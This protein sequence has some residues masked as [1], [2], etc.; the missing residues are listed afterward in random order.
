MPCASNQCISDS[1]L[2]PSASRTV[3]RPFIFRQRGT[4]VNAVQ[5]TSDVHTPARC[6]A[7][8]ISHLAKD[9][10]CCR[11]P[12]PLAVT[13]LCR[14]CSALASSEFKRGRLLFE[15]CTPAGSD[16]PPNGPLHGLVG[17]LPIQWRCVGADRH[18]S[19][20]SSHNPGYCVTKS[21]FKPSTLDSP[22]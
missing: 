17:R 1:Q 9:L 22:S 6:D 3:A 12:S 2:G 8:N 20:S 18:C 19:A 13:D 16:Q 10:K 5:I 7:L 4:A 21:L 11:Q 14:A 15:H